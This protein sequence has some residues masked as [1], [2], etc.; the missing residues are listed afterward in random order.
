ML[1]ISHFVVDAI[2]RESP[3]STCAGDFWVTRLEHRT[4]NL[5]S[6]GGRLVAEHENFDGQPQQMKDPEE[7]EIEK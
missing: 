2:N 6:K 5:P 7:R 3:C 4:G 1:A